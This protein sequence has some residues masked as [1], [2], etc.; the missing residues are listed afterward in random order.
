MIRR[1]LFWLYWKQTGLI[2][3]EEM[4]DVLIQIKKTYKI[5]SMGMPPK[6]EYRKFKV[7]AEYAMNT[8][9]L[10]EIAEEYGITRERVR[11]ITFRIY[12]DYKKGHYI[13]G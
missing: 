7:A 1:F 5:N 9:T 13:N 10:A 8:K 2:H 3:P 12:W 6:W 11:Q 4:R